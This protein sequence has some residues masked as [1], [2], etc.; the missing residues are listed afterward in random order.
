MD[1]GL[2]AP[3]HRCW[4]CAEWARV[5]GEAFGVCGHVDELVDPDDVALF[6][7]DVAGYVTFGADGRLC[8]RWEAR[9]GR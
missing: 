5:R 1:T 6:A 3:E 2:G 7:G 4:A 8:D 9:D